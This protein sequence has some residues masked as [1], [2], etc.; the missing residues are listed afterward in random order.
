MDKKLILI[1]ASAG[2]PNTVFEVLKCLP[3]DIPPIL[4][5]LHMPEK[6]TA[7]F[8]QRINKNCKFDAKEAEDGDILKKGNLYLCPGNRQMALNLSKKGLE[9]SIKDI[10]RVDGYIPSIDYTFNSVSKVYNCKNILGIL[11]TGMGSDG[12]K[13]LKYIHDKGAFVITQ[14]KNSS[15]VYGMPRVA[16]EIGASDIQLDYNDIAN[17]II[18]NFLD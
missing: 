10:G 11:L 3:K 9:I 8:A 6:F 18:K 15:V 2:G 16:F 14:D 1:G 13:S 4:L 5:V 12:A 7:L 17:Y